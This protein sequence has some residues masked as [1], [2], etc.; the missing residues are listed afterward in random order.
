MNILAKNW[1]AAKATLV[2]AVLFLVSLVSLLAPTREEMMNAATPESCRVVE[3]DAIITGTRGIARGNRHTRECRI[4]VKSEGKDIVEEC[5]VEV[6]RYWR[7]RAGNTL[8]LYRG[9]D[10]T[11][12]DPFSNLIPSSRWRNDAILIL[13]CALAFCLN[14]YL[15]YRPLAARARRDRDR[16]IGAALVR[17]RPATP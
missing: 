3:T 10:G 15:H 16:E 6:F 2:F 1:L 9:E 5:V 14:R 11:L 8:T 13:F 7:I 17:D 12:F 4:R